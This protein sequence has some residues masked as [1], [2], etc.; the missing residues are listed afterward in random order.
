MT[1]DLFGVDDDDKVTGVEVRG[2]DGLVFAAK[3]IGNLHSQ[4]SEHGAI[5]INHVP[6]ALVQIHFRQMRFHLKIPIKGRENYQ[7]CG[8]SQ[9]VI[10]I[11]WIGLY[12]LRAWANHVWH[13]ENEPAPA[14]VAGLLWLPLNAS[15]AISTA[16][17]TDPNPQAKKLA[18]TVSMIT[19]VA[20]SPLMGVGAVGAYDYFKAKTA[21]EKAKLPWFAN[22]LFWVPALLLVGACFLKDTAG[23][24]LPTVLKKPFDVAETVEHKISGLVATG[25]FVP[26]AAS[27]FH[28]PATAPTARRWRRSDL[29]PLI[30]TGF[31]TP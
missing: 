7:M 22:P 20:I 14:D 2:I 18:E 4:T 31:T 30:C 8:R 1:L 28:S 16:K 23:I 26:I 24:A 9:Y 3:N 19:G 17:N 13:E 5:G 6:L 29:P 21:E 25:A 10:S 27:I 12:S 11:N 15:A